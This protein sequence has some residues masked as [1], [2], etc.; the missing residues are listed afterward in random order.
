[1]EIRHKTQAGLAVVF[2]HMLPCAFRPHSDPSDSWSPTEPGSHPPGSPGCSQ[3]ESG[4]NHRDGISL[5]SASETLQLSETCSHQSFPPRAPTRQLELLPVKR[6]ARQ[7]APSRAAQRSQRNNTLRW[8]PHKVPKSIPALRLC[9][10][11]VVTDKTL[12]CI[13]SLLAPPDLI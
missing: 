4:I 8:A 9:T 11:L 13:S 10:S 2:A 6:S 7:Q 1:M 12:D 3:P 5:G